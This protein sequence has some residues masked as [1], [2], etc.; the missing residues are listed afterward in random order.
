MAEYVP[1]SK[2]TQ[3]RDGYELHVSYGAA[4]KTIV[5]PFEDVR[6]ALLCA[7]Q[8]PKVDGYGH[9]VSSITIRFTSNKNYNG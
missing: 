6:D 8:M 7:L 9:K 1:L 3:Y 2:E 4:G 5:P